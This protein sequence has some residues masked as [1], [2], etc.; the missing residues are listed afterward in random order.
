MGIFSKL[1]GGTKKSDEKETS[2][3][4]S[5]NGRL[6]RLLDT[7]G[8]EES[9]HSFK[10]VLHELF[11]GSSYLLIP[12]VD[13]G[14]HKTGEWITL[15]ENSTIKITSISE[16]DEVSVLAAFSDEKALFQWAKKETHY[17]AMHTNDL[18]EMCRNMEIGRIVIN[19]G[20]KNMFV[21]ERRK[22][23]GIEETE[24]EENTQI[25]VGIPPI[26]LSKSI[27]GK[28]CNSFTELGFIDE[29]YQYMQEQIDDNGQ[30]ELMLMI[31]IVL[32]ENTD[33][34]RSLA[35]EGIQNSLRGET[36]PEYP[37]GIMIM[38]EHWLETMQSIANQ[39]FYKK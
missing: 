32:D 9:E 12:T 6:I 14:K 2:V 39:P 24:I 34:K 26:P 1:F 28:L 23:D 4:N 5:D 20:Q 38:N 13:D 29:S 3:A 10:A 35:F 30:H 25:R 37:L 27:T 16:Q 7:W 33:E 18:F 15:E 36:K 21:L 31:G 22:D 8:R 19:T 17:T 11:E